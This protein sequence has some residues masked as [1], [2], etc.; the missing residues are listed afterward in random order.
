MRISQLL[1]IAIFSTSSAFA[2]KLT[3]DPNL[4][5]NYDASQGNDLFSWAEPFGQME[6]NQ[7]YLSFFIQKD[8][9][10][11]PV[12]PS[13]VIN[14]K[15]KKGLVPECRDVQWSV[16]NEPMEPE[17]K[18]VVEAK[19]PAGEG[20]YE[21]LHNIF[22]LHDLRNIAA[23]QT[24]KYKLC[25]SEYTMTSKETSGLRGML[26]LYDGDLYLKEY[27]PHD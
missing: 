18:R 13:I 21:T 23:A 24:V 9:N 26:G 5:T 3:D 4:L 22:T 27:V 14:A 16:D 17:S 11:R 1:L 6:L 2:A 12:D 20:V 7:A 25:N 15:T 8:S 10:Y 19:M